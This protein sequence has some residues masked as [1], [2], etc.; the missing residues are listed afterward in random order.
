MTCHMVRVQTQL[1]TQQHNLLKCRVDCSG[2]VQGRV[3]CSPAVQGRVCCSPAVRPICSE[4]NHRV[5]GH[6]GETGEKDCVRVCVCVC[7]DVGQKRWVVYADS[8]NYN[9]TTVTPEWHSWLH[10]I[11]DKPG[12][13]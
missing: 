7:D 13:K 6:R 5:P 11:G 2:S 8:F 10:A 3:C 12:T 1:V 4:P 9:P